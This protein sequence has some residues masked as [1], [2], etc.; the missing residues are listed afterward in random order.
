MVNIPKI[1]YDTGGRQPLLLCKFC[2]SL[3]VHTPTTNASANFVEK[4]HQQNI[5]RKRKRADMVSMGLKKRE[6]VSERERE[7]KEE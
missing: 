5:A 3:K 1:A 6:R 7:D 2:V 4:K